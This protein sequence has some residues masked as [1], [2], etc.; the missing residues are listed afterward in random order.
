MADYII[1]EDD[2]KAILNYL[3]NRP[4]VEV[5][6]AISLLSSLKKIEEPQPK[7]DNVEKKK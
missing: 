3:G 2:L 5:A 1:S 7:Q 4:Y 6:Q